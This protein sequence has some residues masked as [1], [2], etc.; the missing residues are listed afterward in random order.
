MRSFC[1]SFILRENQNAQGCL[2]YVSPVLFYF[3]FCEI[4]KTVSHISVSH[5]FCSAILWSSLCTLYENKYRGRKVGAKSTKVTDVLPVWSKP[6][7][8]DVAREC[9]RHVLFTL[10]ASRETSFYKPLSGMN[11]AQLD[12]GRKPRNYTSLSVLLSWQ[13]S[14][15]NAPAFLGFLLPVFPQ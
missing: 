10:V 12:F 5:G 15:L 7:N 9:I 14:Q 4:L 2:D 11:F 1:F 13:C 8:A 3:K 6:C